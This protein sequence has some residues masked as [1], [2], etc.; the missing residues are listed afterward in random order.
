MSNLTF[1]VHNNSDTK[2]NTTPDPSQT[3]CDCDYPLAL[4]LSY[5]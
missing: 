4:M 3:R 5:H 2:A 1:T